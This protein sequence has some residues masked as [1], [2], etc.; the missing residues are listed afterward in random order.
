MQKGDP[1]LRVE[2]WTPLCDTL[3]ARSD[4]ADDNDVGTLLID[5][6][7]DN[8]NNDHKNHHE[9][10]E[11]VHPPCSNSH[12]NKQEENSGAT[13]FP[14]EEENTR[15]PRLLRPVHF[16]HVIEM[17][18]VCNKKQRCVQSDT[19]ILGSTLLQC[20]LLLI[21]WWWLQR[22]CQWLWQ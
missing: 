12:N 18:I 11:R 22:W 17:C 8:S 15:P 2:S 1:I 5:H 20:S 10:E 16:N 3:F 4:C 13:V 14:A 6:S 7:N 21:S 19:F 9:T